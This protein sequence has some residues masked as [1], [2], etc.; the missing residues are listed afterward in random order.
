VRSVSVL[1]VN[2][3]I[4]ALLYSS[5]F[6]REKSFDMHLFGASVSAERGGVT[7][8]R[9]VHVSKYTKDQNTKTDGE[10]GTNDEKVTTEGLKNTR[11][12]PICDSRRNDRNSAISQRAAEKKRKEK[13]K[14]K[15]RSSRRWIL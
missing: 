4:K 7:F 15:F 11:K 9:L 6:Y 14:T 12:K 5:W 2:I 1:L 8:I 10:N 13:G 3:R